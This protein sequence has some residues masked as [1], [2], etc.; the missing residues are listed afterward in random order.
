[1]LDD[2]DDVHVVILAVGRYGGFA[3]QLY[4]GSKTCWSVGKV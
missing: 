1:M 3:M 2:D 4:Q